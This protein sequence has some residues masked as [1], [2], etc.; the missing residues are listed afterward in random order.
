MGADAVPGIGL[1]GISARNPWSRTMA[2]KNGAGALGTDA[3]ASRTGA[4]ENMIAAAQ[5]RVSVSTLE[6][7]R[8][9]LAS[10]AVRVISCAPVITVLETLRGAHC[11]FS[12]QQQSFSSIQCQRQPQGQRQR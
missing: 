3:R 10:Y 11:W 9:I 8:A 7:A 2:S 5:I 4:A 6:T 12:L 1:L